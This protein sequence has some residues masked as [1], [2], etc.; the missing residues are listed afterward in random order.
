ML[1]YKLLYGTRL[2]VEVYRLLIY[3]FYLT[4]Q[5]VPW[6]FSKTWTQSLGFVIMHIPTFMSVAQ[7]NA[8]FLNELFN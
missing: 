1:L 2:L 8:L 4:G 6:N 7:R 3:R 5:C